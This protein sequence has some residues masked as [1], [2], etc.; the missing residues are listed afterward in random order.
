MSPYFLLNCLPLCIDNQ[1]FKKKNNDVNFDPLLITSFFIL[2]STT[3]LYIDL[4]MYCCF[5]ST[6]HFF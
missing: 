5:D 6:L 2:Q 4:E 3:N 1:Y